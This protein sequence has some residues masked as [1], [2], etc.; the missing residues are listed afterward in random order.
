MHAGNIFAS[1]MAWLIAK[2]QGGDIVLRIEDLDEQ[3]SKQSYIDA[4]Q[5]DYET[6]GLT[7]DR[8]PYYQHNRLDVYR[9]AYETLQSRGLVYPCY[10]TRADIHTASAPH[11]GEKLVYPGT[12]RYLSLEEQ[13]RR[14]REG[15][16]SAQR[17]RVPSEIY[18]LHDLVQGDYCQNLET[19]CGDFIIRRSDG[20]FAYQLAVVVD[21]AQQGINSVVRGVDLLCSTPQQLY[22]QTL[23]GY[24]QPTYAHVPLLVAEKDRR[25]SKRDRDASLEELLKRF[26]TPK[27]MIGHIAFTV[28]L[29]PVFEPCSPEDLLASFRAD[30]VS[31]MFADK[32]QVLWH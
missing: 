15:R 25:L 17:L 3:R 16:R 6:L 19:D 4:L 8:G 23:F 32:I 1:L 28:G 10:C 27:G 9:E 29:I 13:A 21:D 20:A 12:C 11:R 7:W 5:R 18:S 24:D 31:D 14:R 30:L 26:K 2:A 22:L